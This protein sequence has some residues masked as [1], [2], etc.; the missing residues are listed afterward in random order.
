MLWLLGRQVLTPDEADALRIKFAAAS[1]DNG[2]G[3][4][5][6][7]TFRKL[8]SAVCKDFGEKAPRDADLDV[9]FD[10]AD[11]DGNGQVDAEEFLKLYAA[12]RKGIVKGLGSKP[13]AAEQAAEL[14]EAY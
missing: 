7:A 3:N 14:E 9:A 4:L 2:G 13:Q 5:S 8:M 12:V 10:L 11:E 6:K 1:R